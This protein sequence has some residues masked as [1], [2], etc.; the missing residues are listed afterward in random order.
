MVRGIGCTAISLRSLGLSQEGSTAYLIKRN[1]CLAAVTAKNSSR[2]TMLYRHCPANSVS[3]D[4]SM[5]LYL[6]RLAHRLGQVQLVE[7]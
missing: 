3:V 6:L 1:S 7:Q 5:N 2:G 4:T